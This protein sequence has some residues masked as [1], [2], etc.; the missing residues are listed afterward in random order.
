MGVGTELD[1]PLRENL[2]NDSTIGDSSL[3]CRLSRVLGDDEKCWDYSTK[4]HNPTCTIRAGQWKQRLKGEPHLRDA[5]KDL[6]RDKS[7]RGIVSYSLSEKSS[8]SIVR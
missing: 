2:E 8:N 1:A 7:G 3:W 6:C 5:T 4:R